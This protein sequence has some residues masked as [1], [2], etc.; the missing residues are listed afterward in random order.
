MESPVNLVRHFYESF[1][2]LDDAGMCKLYEPGISFF[3]PAFGNLQ[4][5]EVKAM[6]QMLCSRAKDFH[7]V[8]ETPEAL[9]HEYVTCRWTAEYVFSGTGRKVRNVVKA[10]MKVVDGKII[11]HS[12]AFSLHRWSAQ[13]LG[14]KGW[15]LGGSGF[16]QKAIRRKARKGLEG[17][18]RQEGLLV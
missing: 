14:W 16:F 5:N 12:D 2:R 6:W 9:D 10:H 4:G 15:L 1:A 7:L 8:F 3:D 18:M 11:E 13:A 17:F